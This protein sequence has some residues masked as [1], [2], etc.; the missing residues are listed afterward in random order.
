ME[1]DR[2]IQDAIASAIMESDDTDFQSNVAVS[3]VL[4]SLNAAQYQVATTLPGDLQ[5]I[6]CAGSGKT[7]TL[8]SRLMYMLSQGIDPSSIL[9]FTFTNASDVRFLGF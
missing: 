5:V 9:M 4:S 1:L 7:H 6:D 8:T 3:R 2:L